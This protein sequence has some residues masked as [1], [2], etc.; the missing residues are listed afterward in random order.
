MPRPLL[1]IH[2]EDEDIVIVLTANG[3]LEIRS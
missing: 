2:T 3:T 1:E